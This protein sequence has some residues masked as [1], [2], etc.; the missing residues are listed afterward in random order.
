MIA[1]L[2]AGIVGGGA[3]ALLAGVVRMTAA[4]SWQLGAVAGASAAG[5][6]L[7]GTLVLHL[8]RHRSIGAQAAVVALTSVVAVAIGAVTAA[9]RMFISSHDLSSLG[10]VLV[11][12]GTAGSVIALSLGQRVAA[13]SRS[14][15]D[16]ARRIGGGEPMSRLDGIATEELAALAHELDDMSERLSEARERERSLEASRRE[17]VAWVSHDLRTPL[18]GIRAMAEALEDGVVTDGATIARYHSALR[19]ESDRLSGLVDD[20]FELSRINAGTLQ[21]EMEKVSLGDL[22]S[23]A[24][25]AAAGIARAKGVKLEGAVGGEALELELSAAEMARV[26]RNLLENAIRH[27]PGDGTVSV[28]AGIED[29][30]AFVS[31]RDA[32]GGIPPGELERVFDVA[33]RGEA[34]RSPGDHGRGGLGL[35]IA[36]GIVEAHDGAIDVHNEGPGCRFVVVLPLARGGGDGRAP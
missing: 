35:A 4:E 23:D 10:V 26:I 14:L 28:E 7:A 18:A 16:A 13:Q 21:L 3:T 17:L 11:A 30:H 19:V 15:G 20:L 2:V 22:V 25:A 9:G 5:A 36:R 6:G 32:C 1:P 33:F 27:T 12:S 24:L 8:C 34:A 31:V 29:A